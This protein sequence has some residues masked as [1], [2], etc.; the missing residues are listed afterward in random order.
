MFTRD[1]YEAAAGIVYEHLQPTLQHNWPLLAQELGC[2]VWLKHENQTPLGAFKV[3]GGLVHMRRRKEAGKLNGVITASTGNHGQSIPNAARIEGI[4]ATVVVPKNNSAEKNAAMRALGARL[5]EVGDDFADAV[6]YARQLAR[7]ENLDMIPSFHEDLVLGVS[8]YAHE[9]FSAAG[10]LDVVYVPIGLGSG[11]CGTMGMRDMLGLKTKVVGVVA[12]GANTYAL[13]YEA[14]NAVPTNRAETFAEGVAVREPNP[15]AVA[16]INA[17]AD[18][19]VEV[20]DAQIQDAMRL[21]FR[22]THNIAEGAGAVALAA[23]MA[24]TAQL[25]G[26]RVGAVLSGGNI[27]AAKYAAILSGQMDAGRSSR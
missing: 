20:T 11:I 2:E 22:A 3:R 12:K 17:G 5:I 23:V 9:L 18:H 26:Q 7:D 4:A 1:A 25:D 14:G 10:A 8:T 16:L 13:S 21:I 24:E 19:I 27:D 6:A 15:E